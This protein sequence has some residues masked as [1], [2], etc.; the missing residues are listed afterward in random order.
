MSPSNKFKNETN[1]NNLDD[2][3]THKIM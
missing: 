1:D 2:G 3:V